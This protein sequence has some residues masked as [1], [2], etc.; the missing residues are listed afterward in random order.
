MRAMVIVVV[1]PLTE[2]LVEQVDV[3]GDAVLVEQLVEL[4]IVDPVRAFDLAVEVR[5]TRPDVHVADIQSGQVPMKPRLK[6][7][8]VVPSEERSRQDKCF[9]RMG[10]PQLTLEEIA[11]H[12]L[13]FFYHVADGASRD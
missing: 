1:L 7:G 8:A 9:S 13:T 10:L 5:G 6:L 4:L 12:D 11:S 2:L 3:V